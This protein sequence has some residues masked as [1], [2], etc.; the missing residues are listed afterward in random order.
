MSIRNG[1]S[2]GLRPNSDE[3][4]WKGEFTAKDIISGRKDKTH[5]RPYAEGKDLENY[6][7][8][9][10]RYLEWG[11]DRVPRKLVR[12]TFPE[13][14]E[15]PKIMRGCLTGGIYDNSGLICNH[16]IVVFVRFTDLRGVN[17][18]S[19]QSSIKKFNHW[20]RAELE[21]ISERFDLKYILAIL[22]SSLASL[23][24]NNIRRHRLENYFYPDDLRKLPVAD[25]SLKEQEPFINLVE[26]ICSVT[27]EG[28][29]VDDAVKQAKVREYKRRIDQLVYKLYDLTEEEI[30]TVKDAENV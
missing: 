7:I 27:K 18:K 20:P 9:R 16:S 4:Y 8:N 11:T 1:I 17:N 22:N 26:K 21:R 12:P 5:S 24:L 2:Y 14:Y 25:I 10:I 3:R 30:E 23:Y 6:L 29:Y 19:I 28:D 13:L 15:R